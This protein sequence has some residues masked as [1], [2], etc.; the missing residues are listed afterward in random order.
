M[1]VAALFMWAFQG[2]C[3]MLIT[4]LW[5]L[6]RDV[7]AKAEKATNDLSAYKL[8]V[9][10]KYTTGEELRE[11]VAAINRAFDGYSTKLDN[12]LDRLEERILEARRNT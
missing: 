8:D 11:A 1:D 9:A 7:K 5:F 4:V 10:E 6:F 12:R 3:A 2:V